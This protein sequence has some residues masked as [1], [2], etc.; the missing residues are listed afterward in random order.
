MVK[1]SLIRKKILKCTKIKKTIIRERSITKWF[2]DLPALGRFHK[3]AF[4]RLLTYVNKH[5]NVHAV[6]NA[7]KNLDPNLH[8]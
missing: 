4:K 7:I 8:A 3:I 6:L 2:P 5:L 1:E